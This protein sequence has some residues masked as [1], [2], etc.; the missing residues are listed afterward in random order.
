[1]YI[2]DPSLLRVSWTQQ[3]SCAASTLITRSAGVADT[4]VVE[5]LAAGVGLALGRTEVEAAAAGW[6]FLSWSD[7]SR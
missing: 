4:G 3:S 7:T 1:M 6:P 5:V 2:C